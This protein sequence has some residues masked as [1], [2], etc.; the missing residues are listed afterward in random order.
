MRHSMKNS[1]FVRLLTLLVFV[2]ALSQYALAA[3]SEHDGH[4]KA[5][6]HGGHDSHGGHGGHGH[7]VGHFTKPLVTIYPNAANE[8][9]AKYIF[10]DEAHAKAH[11]GEL[12]FGYLFTKN[13]S[14][15]L[16]VPY[17]YHDPKSEG[18]G[19]G[20]DDSHG[21]EHASEDSH[22]DE[23]AAEEEDHE[24]ESHGDSHHRS[25]SLRAGGGGDGHG[26]SSESNLGNVVLGLK[27]QNNHWSDQNVLVG[28]GLGIEF[29]TGDSSKGIG[30]DKLYRLQPFY[31]IGYKKDLFEV[32][33]SGKFFIPL[34]SEEG[35]A[36]DA[37][38]NFAASFLYFLSD[39]LRAFVEFDGDVVMEG[40]YDG[41]TVVNVNPG[42]RHRL[43]HGVDLG[44]G[45]G[46]PLTSKEHFDPRAIVSVLF[47][48]N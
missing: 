30:S 40:K 6:A 2:L 17:I 5:D 12:E 35:E 47:E 22:G 37:V 18:G 23:H 31:S 25:A 34:S 1:T 36:D 19:H 24:E 27:L 43:F 33:T 28:Y 29:P 9:E 21:D 39:S 46:F 11:E 4:G 44:A 7:G 15:E 26:S 20:S 48:F 38:F 16:K 13:A 32:I 42:L 3:D 14:V 8:I 10:L 45:I 41:D